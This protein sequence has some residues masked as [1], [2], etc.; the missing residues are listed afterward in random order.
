MPSISSVALTLHNP[1]IS[2][3]TNFPL[4]LWSP[5]TL[6][7]KQWQWILPWC[8]RP[9]FECH[10]DALLVWSHSPTTLNRLL[11]HSLALAL[12]EIRSTFHFHSH[13]L[14]RISCATSTHI[15]PEVRLKRIDQFATNKLCWVGWLPQIRFPYL[16]LFPGSHRSTRV[17]QKQLQVSCLLPI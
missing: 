10:G 8:V 4:F 12:L 11:F 7:T 3:H 16:W 14:H 13:T 9:I 17:L 1:M 15:F 2:L 6:Y 5:R